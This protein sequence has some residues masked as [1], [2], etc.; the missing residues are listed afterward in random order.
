MRLTLDLWHPECW[1]LEVTEAVDAGLLGHGVYTVDGQANGRF[2]AYAETTE[3]VD[4]LVDEIEAS[5]LT[6]AVWVV[7]DPGVVDETIPGNASRRLVVRYD[8]EKSI[9]DALVSRGFIPDEPVRMA[10]GRESWTVIADC[11]RDDALDRLAD[12][13]AELDADIAVSR[14]TATEQSGAG[15][16]PLDDLSERQREV[17]ETARDEGY[18]AWPRHVSAADLADDLDVSKATLLEH[19]RKAEA[20]LLGRPE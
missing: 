9:N 5:P 15:V 8:I 12:I 16:L 13:E 19:L 7:D 6:D 4:E 1:T 17:F 3:E 2:T 11:T 20:K 10:D 14:V 18:Y